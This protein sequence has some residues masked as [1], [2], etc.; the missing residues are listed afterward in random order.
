MM[1]EHDHSHFHGVDKAEKHI[2]V[3][4]AVKMLVANINPVKQETINALDSNNR[5]LA[6]DLK[7]PV[8]L[9]RR[10]RATRD[11]F[12]VNIGQDAGAGFSFKVVGSVRIGKIPQISVGSGEAVRVATG[13]Y[14]PIGANAVVMV[15]YVDAH[16]QTVLVN[17]SIE[18]H[19]NILNEGE[20]VSQGQLLLLKGERV[21]PQ[22][23]ALFSMLGLR[24]V[25]VFSKPRVA[26]FSTGDEL[27]DLRR[28]SSKSATVVYDATRPF[29]ASMIS[30]LGG[31]PVDLGIVRDNFAQTK[32]KMARGLKYD[33]LI[34]SAGSSVGERDYVTRA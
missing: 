12:A 9:P 25:K 28:P 20:D 7:S 4:E 19:Q 22:H 24:K 23:V 34:L 10:A 5:F 27:V 18:V 6:E 21:H 14:L 29:I 31:V 30:N 16:D 13:S 33:A 1:E 2:S 11:G 32:L 15:E 8:N 3:S 17:R 26:F